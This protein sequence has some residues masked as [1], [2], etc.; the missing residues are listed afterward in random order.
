MNHFHL[1]YTI[2]QTRR[3]GTTFIE[4]KGDENGRFG[5]ILNDIRKINLSFSYNFFSPLRKYCKA[6]ISGMYNTL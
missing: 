5:L 4:N 3:L 2:T 1:H 6:K